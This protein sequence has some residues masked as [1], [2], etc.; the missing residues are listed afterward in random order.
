VLALKV[1]FAF[2]NSSVFRHLEGVVY[3]LINRGHQVDIV[4]SL[5]DGSVHPNVDGRALLEAAGTHPGLAL[6]EWLPGVAVERGRWTPLIRE[7][8]NYSTYYRPG[9]PSRGLRARW[10][11]YLPSWVW[12]LVG[13]PL[14]G[15]FLALVPVR[16]IFRLVENLTPPSALITDWIR[17]ENVD[18]VIGCPFLL[19]HAQEVDYIKAAKAAGLPT[20]VVVQSWDNLTTKG[21]FQIMPDRV[22]VWNEALRD[23]AISLHDVPD[24]SIVI[25]GSPT[26]DYWFRSTPTLNRIQFSVQCGLLSDRPY[27]VYLCSSRGMIEEEKR[28]VA[29]LAKELRLD[30]QTADI[31][32]LVRPHPLNMLDWSDIVSER[33]VVWPP[34]G[35]NTDNPQARINFFHSLYY[36]IAAVGVN[37]SAMLEAAIADR[38]CITV[39]DER[40]KSAQTDMGHFRHLLNGNFLQVAK[41]YAEAVENIGAIRKGEDALAEGRRDFVARF[42]R[43]CG[44][45]L[46]ASENMAKA[47]EDFVCLPQR[48]D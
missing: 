46:S 22:L 36:A 47:I 6:H 26:F 11:K 12:R 18:V 45:E 25:T 30:P 13:F 9:H 5:D 3:E 23:E 37:T 33:V 31:D 20:M 19:P 43:P 16:W 32:L 42:V 27:I 21:T 29:D 40:Y 2:V 10:K 39:L 15:K 1:A 4:T 35:E 41:S 24:E 8:L 48:A 28:Y 38:P 34:Q 14:M 7:L 44:V 17:N